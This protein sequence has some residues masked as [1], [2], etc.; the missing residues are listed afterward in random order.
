M[1]GA[2]IREEILKKLSHGTADFWETKLNESDVP[3]A[4]VRDLHDMLT[5]EQSRRAQH[6]R[7]RRL[8]DSSFTA[9]IAAFRY[10]EDGPELKRHCSRQ[11]EDNAT[12]LAELGYDTDAISRLADNGVI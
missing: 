6:S 12:V 10:A 4:R 1:N 5:N 11:G 9:P 3:A 7:Y 2:R 8:E